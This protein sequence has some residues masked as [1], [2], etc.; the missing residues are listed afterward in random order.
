MIGEARYRVHSLFVTPGIISC[1]SLYGKL[2]SRMIYLDL[3]AETKTRALLLGHCFSYLPDPY[4]NFFTA[5]VSASQCYYPSIFK[6]DTLK[7]IKS[8]YELITCHLL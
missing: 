2:K 4:Q 1:L 6:Y 7:E 8:E 5:V 3:F